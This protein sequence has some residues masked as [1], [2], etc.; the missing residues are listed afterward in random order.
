M[1]F[2]SQKSSLLVLVSLLGDKKPDRRISYFLT[3]PVSIELGSFTLKDFDR[4]S[5]GFSTVLRI[6]YYRLPRR[7]GK[8]I[9]HLLSCKSFFENFLQ[10]L[11][12]ENELYLRANRGRAP[13]NHLR[14]DQKNV[15]V[16]AKK[17]CELPRK[18]SLHRLPQNPT[19]FRGI[20]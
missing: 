1:T 4:L 5:T 14:P 3:R 6:G 15:P 2:Y 18:R 10:Q 11:N 19:D 17:L 16:R 13:S 9:R 20:E 12:R 7:D 8:I